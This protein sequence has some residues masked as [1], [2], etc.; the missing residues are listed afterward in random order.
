MLLPSHTPHLITPELSP[1]KKAS[2][3]SHLW[4]PKSPRLLGW[5]LFFNCSC[6]CRDCCSPPRK[7]QSSSRTSLASILSFSVQQEGK[8]KQKQAPQTQWL[9]SSSSYSSFLSLTFVSFFYIY[10]YSWHTTQYWNSDFFNEKTQERRRKIKCTPIWRRANRT[11]PTKN[12]YIYIYITTTTKWYQKTKL[13]NKSS[14]DKD[15]NRHAGGRR[16]RR[17]RY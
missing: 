9:F 17:R 2:S 3:S 12:N 16:R 8:N 5:V 7:Q 15:S 6:C 4:Y 10:Y 13:P 1:I 11:H 14:R